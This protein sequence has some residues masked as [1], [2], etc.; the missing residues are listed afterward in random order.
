MVTRIKRTIEVIGNDSKESLGLLHVYTGDG[1]GKT[2]SSLGLGLRAVGDNLRVYMIQFL[3]S[4]ET[5]EIKSIKKY[6]PNMEI[7]QYGV[8]ALREKQSKLFDFSADSKDKGPTKF[9][10]LPD[11]EEKD[12]ARMGLEH[13]KHILRTNEYDVLILDEI[14]V[15]LDKELVTM[16]EFKEFFSHNK[17]IEIICTGRDAPEELKDMADYVSEIKNIKHPWQKGI[18]ARKGIDY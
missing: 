16:K 11:S 2:S 17:K 6:L 4:G 14:N 5:G 7:V 3:K 9:R 13:A 1:K 15:A 12:A 10:F 18:V 8:D